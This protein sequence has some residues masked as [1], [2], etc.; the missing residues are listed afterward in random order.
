[1]SGKKKSNLEQN[2]FTAK[3]LGFRR[4]CQ[5]VIQALRMG[6][7]YLILL[8]NIYMILEES[9]DLNKVQFPHVNS[10]DSNSIHAAKA[11]SRCQHTETLDKC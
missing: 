5:D 11:H 4:Q 9:L 2:T 1:M 8:L 3:D 10:Q 7:L 6:S